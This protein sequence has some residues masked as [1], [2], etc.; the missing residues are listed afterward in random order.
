V[1]H[2]V[3]KNRLVVIRRV[4]YEITTRAAVE[5]YTV[6]RMGKIEFIT[7]FLNKELKITDI[8]FIEEKLK[9]G[10]VVTL[11]IKVIQLYVVG[12]RLKSIPRVHCI[13]LVVIS[14]KCPHRF[15]TRDVNIKFIKHN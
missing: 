8:R 6:T 15:G 7:R 1:V 3:R 2:T 11:K 4:E 12:N 9:S 13:V 5:S 10:A 14:K